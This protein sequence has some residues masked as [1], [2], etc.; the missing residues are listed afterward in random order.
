MQGFKL[1]V[2]VCRCVSCLAGESLSTQARSITVACPFAMKRM[3]P[4]AG[5]EPATY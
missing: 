5:F 2:C 4:T 3:E 1:E